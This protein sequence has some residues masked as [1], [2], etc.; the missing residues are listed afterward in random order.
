MAR[1]YLFNAGESTDGEGECFQ[2]ESAE[3]AAEREQISGCFDSWR[4]L[5]ADV[6]PTKA[7]RKPVSGGVNIVISVTFI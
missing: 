7:Q 4:G 3:Q 2:R 6:S 5:W 1:S